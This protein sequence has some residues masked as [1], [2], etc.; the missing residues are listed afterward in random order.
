[1]LRRIDP[2]L[3]VQWYYDLAIRVGLEVIRRLQR[4]PYY[5]VVVDFAIDGKCYCVVVVDQRLRSRIHSHY[6]EALVA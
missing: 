5:S 3:L 2:V 4:L 6:T 1:M